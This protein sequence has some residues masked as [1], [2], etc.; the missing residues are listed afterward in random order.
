[1]ETSPKR[2]TVQYVCKVSP[3]FLLTLHWVQSDVKGLLLELSPLDVGV[4]DRGADQEAMD[5]ACVFTQVPEDH[6]HLEVLA[7]LHT[8]LRDLQRHLHT[9]LVIILHMRLVG[10]LGI[11]HGLFIFTTACVCVGSWRGIELTWDWWP[12]VV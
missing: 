6:S 3:W 2:P 4:V 10:S 5:G 7:T 12:R 9:L 8:L 1:M 11:L